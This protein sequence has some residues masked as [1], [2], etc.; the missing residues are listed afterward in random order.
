MRVARSLVWIFVGGLL[1]LA[2]CSGPN[3]EG[4]QRAASSTT[5]DGV[6]QEKTPTPTPSQRTSEALAAPKQEA[7]DPA[8]VKTQEGLPTIDALPDPSTIP[9]SPKGLINGD[10]APELD[11]FDLVSGQQFKL[12][13]RVGPQA[14]KP[15]G[16]VVV[17][18]TASWC[19]PCRASLPYLKEMEERFPELDV[20]LGTMDKDKAGRD[21]ELAQLRASGLQAPLLVPDEHTLR[22]WLG[23]KRNIPHLYI[24]NAVGEVLVQ[25]RG[26]GKKVRK[27]LPGQISYALRHPEYVVR[28]KKVR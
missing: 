13:T 12:S 24:I 5:S 8:A 15:R 26:F 18:F 14:A 20:V 11:H 7:T 16:A 21:K 17:S 19:G 25:D 3:A 23:R 9:D 28:A 27:V 2:A 1:S 6:H 22:A 10:F 4:E